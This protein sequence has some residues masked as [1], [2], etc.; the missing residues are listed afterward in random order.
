MIGKHYMREAC[1]WSNVLEYASNPEVH[2]LVRKPCADCPAKLDAVIPQEN[3]LLRCVDAGV[4]ELVEDHI[5]HGACAGGA[6][7]HGSFWL[8]NESVVSVCRCG[9]VAVV[10]SL[11]NHD[12]ALDG[13]VAIATS[14]F[15]T[16][17][18]RREVAESRCASDWRANE[19]SKDRFSGHCASPY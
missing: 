14:L 16:E 6:K 1:T 13:I 17:L 11:L 18:A 7:E 12:A 10:E 4:L 3:V 9:R 8:N 19:R 2:R 5:K 15:R